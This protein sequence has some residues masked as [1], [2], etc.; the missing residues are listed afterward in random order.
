MVRVLGHCHFNDITPAIL[1]AATPLHPITALVLPMLCTRYA[2]NDRSLFT[3]LTSEEPLS[4][5]NF[6]DEATVEGDC[7]R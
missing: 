2:Q 1:A 5:K 6:L 3:F 7:R 4:F